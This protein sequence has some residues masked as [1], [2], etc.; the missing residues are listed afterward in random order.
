MTQWE[1]KT[2][3]VQGYEGITYILNQ[4]G[5]EGWEA[6]AMTSFPLDQLHLTHQFLMKRQK[7]S[8]EVEVGPMQIHRIKQR[9]K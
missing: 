7:Q 1:Y 4:E 8:R 3:Q 2:V 6:V 5:N 9:G